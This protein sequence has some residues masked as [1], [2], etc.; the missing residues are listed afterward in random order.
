[1]TFYLSAVRELSREPSGLARVRDAFALT[2]TE[3][4]G[5][6]DVSRQAIDSWIEKGA[7]P[8]R[9]AK[10]GTLLALVDVLEHQLKRDRLP[11]IARR[12]ADA[13]GG[14]TMLEMIRD[15]RQD[16]VLEI[17]RRSF[18]WSVAA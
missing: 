6:F 9:Q 11:G 2:T 16:E 13:Y 7:P 18:D 1:M 10:I 3:L 5:L 14:R 4:G 12:P 8:A 17:T 15:D